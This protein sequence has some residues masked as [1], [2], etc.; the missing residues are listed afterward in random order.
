MI[1]AFSDLFN[2]VRSV[3][4]QEGIQHQYLPQEKDLFD[5]G[6]YQIKPELTIQQVQQVQ[7][8]LEAQQ[9]VLEVQQQQMQQ[10]LEELEF[11]FVLL[12]TI[13]GLGGVSVIGFLIWRI[14]KRH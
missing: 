8:V 2:K 3:A 5:L 11:R 6:M 13:I 7:Q 12:L 9:L 4:Y 10:K 1:I 14:R